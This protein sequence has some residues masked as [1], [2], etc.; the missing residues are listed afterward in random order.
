MQEKILQVFLYTH[1]AKFNEIEKQVN[2]RSNKLAYHLK[3]LEKKG[4][5]IKE[6]ENY[7]LSETAEELIPYLSKKK[8]ILPVILIA[9][10]NKDKIFL[11]KRE[12]RPF[13][14]K[15]SLPGGRILLKETIAEA[16]K[17]IIKKYNLNARLKKINSVSLEQVKSKDK[18]IHSFILI[19]V[20][21]I[22]KDKI[23]LT[24]QNQNKSKIIS[25]DYKLI[26]ND[27]FSFKHSLVH[28]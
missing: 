10:G 16:T 21:A 17:R 15:L 22:T 23:Q 8:S 24:S 25:S 20:T 11:Y 6:K 27:L 7:K 9:I 1:K 4:I 12:K 28:S 13:K 19:F 2:I 18:L 14:N 5:L 3:N 26:I